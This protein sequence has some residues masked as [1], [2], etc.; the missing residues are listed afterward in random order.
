MF[1]GPWLTAVQIDLDDDLLAG[2]VAGVSLAV[3]IVEVPEHR[4]PGGRVGRCARELPEPSGQHG[5]H[6]VL[7]GVVVLRPVIALGVRAGFVR[8]V[9]IVDPDHA[10]RDESRRL[11]P[12][13]GWG[14]PARTGE[15]PRWPSA[16]SARR[17]R[18]PM[19]VPANSASV[20]RTIPR[21]DKIPPGL[22]EKES[23]GQKT[24]HPDHERRGNRRCRPHAGIRARL[25]LGITR[26]RNQ[27]RDDNPMTGN[28]RRFRIRFMARSREL[29]L[30]KMRF[31]CTT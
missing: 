12:W 25:G 29:V 21:L 13:A 17:R 18:C 27:I 31:Y 14:L 24:G 7:V 4:V 20:K 8:G 26:M 11:F 30:K 9:G 1:L 19:T 6:R 15:S 28:S 22:L 16:R 5:I 10:G 23:R 2:R 3:L